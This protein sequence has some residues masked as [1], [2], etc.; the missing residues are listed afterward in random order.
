MEES[1]KF[2]TIVMEFQKRH[3]KSVLQD[4]E[5]GMNGFLLILDANEDEMYANKLAKALNLSR[6]RLSIIAHSLHRRGLINLKKSEADKRKELICLTAKGKDVIKEKKIELENVV[7]KV[8]SRLDKND[9]DE[10]IRI[11]EKILNSEKTDEE[12]VI[13]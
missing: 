2:L 1:K 9:V 5:K 10:L 3:C 6:A 11:L 13:C 12:D 4:S 7:D 8:F